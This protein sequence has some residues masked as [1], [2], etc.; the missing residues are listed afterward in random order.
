MPATVRIT[1]KVVPN[2]VANFERL[3]RKSASEQLEDL[4]G[5]LKD[6]VQALILGQMYLWVPLNPD[7]LKA[8][9]KG[10]FDPRILVRTK[11][12]VESIT[13]YS[14]GN[15]SDRIAFRVSP[16]VGEALHNSGL[17]FVE[18][19]RVHEFGD[20]QGRIP[21][22]P[23][24]RVVWLAFKTQQL[25]QVVKKLRARIFSDVKKGLL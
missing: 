8:K 16:P 19:A 23:H 20:R 21:S 4:G 24:W 15:P 6:Q 12:Y 5:G 2:L 13:V 25:F 10:G 11:E 7:Y 3:V 9:I 18:L 22:R 14:L 17:T 1:R